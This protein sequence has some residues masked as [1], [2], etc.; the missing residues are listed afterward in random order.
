MAKKKAYVREGLILGKNRTLREICTY[1]LR[2]L[3]S[4]HNM[5]SRNKAETFNFFNYEGV[6]KR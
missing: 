3:L 6:K 4:L 5:R 1:Q 2:A